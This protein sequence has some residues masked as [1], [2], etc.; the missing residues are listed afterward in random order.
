[1]ARA[2][3]KRGDGAGGGRQR[4]TTDAQRSAAGVADHFEKLDQVAFEF[5]TFGVTVYAE[6]TL[7]V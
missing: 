1:M 7:L 4:K 3:R 2:K 5:R 6:L